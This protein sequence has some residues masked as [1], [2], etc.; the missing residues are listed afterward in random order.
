MTTDADKGRRGGEMPYPEYE[1]DQALLK[2]YGAL[3]PFEVMLQLDAAK[4]RIETLARMD[5]EAATHVEGLICVRTHFT[6]E[7]PYVGWEGLGLALTEHLDRQE[8]R[9]AELEGENAA[10]Q[11]SAESLGELARQRADELIALEAKAAEAH[12]TG[13]MACRERAVEVAAANRRHVEK[14]PAV[15]AECQ[16]YGIAVADDIA[17]AISLLEPEDK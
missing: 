9:I 5:R 1:R 11:K 13:F 17:Q 2:K 3:S 4:Q 6:G 10:L 16:K 7:P 14:S 8:Q 12:R 15:G